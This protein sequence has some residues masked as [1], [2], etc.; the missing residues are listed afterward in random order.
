MPHLTCIPRKP[1]P[2][3]M[4][5]KALYDVESGVSL[6]LEISEGKA[7]NKTKNYAD[8][9]P[10]HVALVLRLVHDF[11]GT[12]RVLRGDSAFASYILCTTLLSYGV[13]WWY[14]QTSNHEV[15]NGV[16]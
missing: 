15:P 2:R 4:E 1:R 7:S 8:Q 3:G 9:F 13:F 14:R 11:M 10:H 6:R 12:W 5:I 16:F